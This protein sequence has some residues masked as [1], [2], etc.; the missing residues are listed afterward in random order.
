MQLVPAFFRSLFSTGETN[1]FFKFRFGRFYISKKG[2][3]P[4]R[5]DLFLSFK[6]LYFMK[7]PL[8]G[9]WNRWGDDDVAIG[10]FVFAKND[11]K[12]VYVGIRSACKDQ[13]YDKC[14]FMIRCWKLT[15]RWSLPN[16]IKPHLVKVKANW[17]EATVKRMGRDWY[18]NSYYREYSIG[19]YD[20]HL[21][22]EYGIQN[23]NGYGDI[24]SKRKGWFLPWTQW[25]FIRRSL[26][27]LDGKLFWECYES[28]D[29]AVNRAN[30][31]VWYEKKK[32]CPSA[33][34]LF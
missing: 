29:R 20:G 33:Y 6:R 28:K 31:D 2:D 8:H 30:M 22:M 13:E 5:D 16:I 9:R 15:F 32:E 3:A 17:D 23:E 19:V 25:R 14:V 12:W 26:Y 10:N 21:S 1:E 27:D 11:P 4:Q 18:H 7:R 24:K 34:F